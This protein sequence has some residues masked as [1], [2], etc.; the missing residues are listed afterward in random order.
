[1][2]N[3]NFDDFDSIDELVNDEFFILKESKETNK[4][5]DKRRRLEDLLEEKRLRAEL[6]EFDGY[7]GKNTSLDNDDMPYN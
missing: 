6:D 2:E 4:Y 3:N 1:M 5:S 7:F